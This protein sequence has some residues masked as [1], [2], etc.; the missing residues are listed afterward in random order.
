LFIFLAILISIGEVSGQEIYSGEFTE[1]PSKE[2]LSGSTINY[3]EI[4]FPS[5]NVSFNIRENNSTIK[6]YQTYKSYKLDVKGGELSYIRFIL[7]MDGF[8]NNSKYHGGNSRV[9]SGEN[10][11]SF[12]IDSIDNEKKSLYESYIPNPNK[13]IAIV[14]KEN[15]GDNEVFAVNPEKTL[16]ADFLNVNSSFNRVE[17]CEGKLS[18]QNLLIENLGEVFPVKILFLMLI[19]TV[20]LILAKLGKT[21]ISN[22][23]I[24][25]HNKDIQQIDNLTSNIIEKMQNGEIKKNKEVLKYLMKANKLAQENR[26]KEAN[27]MIKNIKKQFK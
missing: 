16:C 25:H 15:I 7:D 11:A 4:G 8:F 24:K 23:I 19:F 9:V 20:I 3:F 21:K 13:N 5:D 12:D 22:N 6:R 26:Y 10:L 1:S 27:R 14:G 17:D 18:K 2:N